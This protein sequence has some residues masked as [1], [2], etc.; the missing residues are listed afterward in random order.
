MAVIEL[1]LPHLHKVKAKGRLYFYAWRGGP[2]IDVDP[3]DGETFAA[4]YKALHAARKGGDKSKISGL[5]VDWKASDAWAR[6]AGQ[7]GM[8]EAT[9]ANWKRWLDEVHAHFGTLSVAQFDRPQIRPLIKKWRNKWKA[10]PRAADMAKQVLSALLT[11]AVEE[12][13]LAA[14]PCFGIPNL[15]KND[16]SEIIWTDDDMARLVI[17][18][19]PREIVYALE[20]AALTGLRQADLLG[21]TWGHVGDLAIEKRTGKSGNKRTALVPLYGELRELL[22]EIRAYS[23]ERAGVFKA[24]KRKLP[25]AVHILTNTEG[26][27]WKTGFS[28]SWNK[29]MIR[30]EEETLHFHDARGTFATRAYLAGFTIR[31]I[32]ELLAW[33]EDQVERI[34][35]RYVRRN[36]LLEDRIRRMD[37]ARKQRDG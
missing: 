17:S 9:K 27:P 8:A 10:T 29:A 33:S 12:G 13:R 22:E 1:E 26:L 11:F 36:A 37:E 20:L 18:G 14:N 7:G 19:A 31:E 21:L 2:R 5:I 16:R 24:E 6:D 25:G 15:Y 4:E 32:A 23:A 35:N 34:I 30:M 3:A 28:S